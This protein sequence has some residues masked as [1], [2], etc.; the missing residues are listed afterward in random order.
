MY[1]LTHP[2]GSSQPGKLLQ[3]Q[4]KLSREEFRALLE[5]VDRGLRALPATAQVRPLYCVVHW[6][7][8]AASILRTRTLL[9]CWCLA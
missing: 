9:R 7:F 2:P 6:G 4:D 5:H 8:I 1:G 3:W